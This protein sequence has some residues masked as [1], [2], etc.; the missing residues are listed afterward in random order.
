MGVQVLFLIDGRGLI[1]G[2]IS[3]VHERWAWIDCGIA[4]Q[5]QSPVSF[6]V[7]IDF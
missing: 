3:F 6:F 2:C 7:S 1:G 4:I 5:W